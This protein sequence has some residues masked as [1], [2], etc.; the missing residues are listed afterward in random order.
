MVVRFIY[1][2]FPVVWR[3]AGFFAY[4]AEQ[5]YLLRNDA[6]KDAVDLWRAGTTS[7]LFFVGFCETAK[8]S[9]GQRKEMTSEF[10]IAVHTLVFLNHKK[11]TVCSQSLAENVCTNP[12]RIR[13][14]MAKL[15][16]AGLVG[17]KEGMDGG[18]YFEKNP[19][20][21]TLRQIDEAMDARLV[22]SSW[23]PGNKEK[24]CLIAS[25]MG[26]I[27]DNIYFEL[28]QKCKQYLKGITISDIDKKIF[29]E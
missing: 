1:R 6:G 7:F 29:G 13:K 19:K 18:Y 4:P 5:R 28:D 17:T 20:E 27:L 26:E 11:T 21:V 22:S 25:G 16:K 23:K 9:G 10:A 3:Y 12:A 2:Y 14:V 8:T 15:K 24:E